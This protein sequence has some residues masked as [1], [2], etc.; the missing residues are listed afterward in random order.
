MF[1]RAFFWV[2]VC[3]FHAA[4]PALAR[5]GYVV[6]VEDDGAVVVSESR[7]L[8]EPAERYLFYGVEVPTARQPFGPE[9]LTWLREKLPQG[10][11]I[12]VESVSRD[13]AGHLRA[14]IQLGSDSINY[15]LLYQ[16]FAWVNRAQCRAVFCRRWYIQE[17]QA[18]VEKRGLWSMPM[19]T[20]PWQWGR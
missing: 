13:R 3:S 10:A 19:S 20:P 11:R 4:A 5:E 6:R 12:N 15:Q 8:D 1:A 16:G 14:L 17:H 7:V 18:V 9:S 2:M